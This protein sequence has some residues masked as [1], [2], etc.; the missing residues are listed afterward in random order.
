MSNEIKDIIGKTIVSSIHSARITAAAVV[1]ALEDAGYSIEKK[2]F[3]CVMCDAGPGLACSKPGCP[4][5]GM[6]RRTPD[7][8]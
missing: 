3:G 4:Q 5:I 1:T 7:W 8:K 2:Q 6:V